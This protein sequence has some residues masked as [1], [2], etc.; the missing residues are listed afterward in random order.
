MENN[1]DTDFIVIGSGIAGLFVALKLSDAGKVV[2]FTKNSMRDCSTNIAQGGIAVPI[3]PN[4]SK[5]M[6]IK[7]TLLVGAGLCN[8]KA[9]R[10]LVEEGVERV[11][12]LISLGVIFDKNASG[13]IDLGREAAHSLN[14]ILHSGDSTGQA[15][16]EVLIKNVKNKKNISIVENTKIVS[17]ISKDGCCFG[18]IT[19]KGQ[20]CYS[21]ATVIATGGIGQLYKNTTNPKGIQGEGIVLAYESGAEL[22]DLEFVQFHPTGFLLPTYKSRMLLISEALRGEG[23]VLRNVYRHQFID[24]MVARD[25]LTKA[26]F[27]E[28]KK[29]KSDHVLLDMSMS[30]INVRNRFPNI[31]RICKEAKV[32]ISKDLIPVAPVAH[33]FMGGIKTD[34]NGSTNIANLYAVGESACVGVDGANRLAS[35]SLLTCLVFAHR[36]SEHVFQKTT[37]ITSSSNMRHKVLKLKKRILSQGSLSCVPKEIISNIRNIFW[38]YV[39]IVRSKKGLEKALLTLEKM[40]ECFPYVVM[41]KLITKAALVREESRGGHFREDYPVSKDIYDKHFVWSRNHGCKVYKL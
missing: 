5:E 13:E 1:T 19:E 40:P 21:K 3:A 11:E 7:D 15:I 23:A 2:I 4:D 27:Y 12:E 6:H 29:T 26:I 9:V 36:V 10:V 28:M 39:G 22:I 25:V 17:L 35:N 20:P 41:A 8:E 34:L 30:D 31:Y 24:G 37:E 18:V 16:H 33:Y 38:N 32:N 14:R